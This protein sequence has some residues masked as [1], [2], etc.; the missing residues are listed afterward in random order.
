MKL[1]KHATIALTSASAVVFGFGVFVA[2]VSAQEIDLVTPEI[3]QQLQEVL[4]A[5]DT[6]ELLVDALTQVESQLAEY[7][8]STYS[9][10]V[11][12][13]QDVLQLKQI[14]RE[15]LEQLRSSLSTLK[16]EDKQEYLQKIRLRRQKSHEQISQLRSDALGKQQQLNQEQKTQRL[17]ELD[18]RR[19]LFKENLKG[20][21]EQVQQQKVEADAEL[22]HRR[23]LFTENLNNRLEA[24]QERQ[25][26]ANEK[27]KNRIEARE[28]RLT[29]LESRTETE[30]A[31]DAKR[32]AKAREQV[33][34]AIDSQPSN[35]F[36]QIGYWLR[37]L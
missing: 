11:N 27:F 4:G 17:E 8:V 28:A 33:K 20:R 6:D 15:Y 10:K 5:G 22:E 13:S 29:E 14:R 12:D 23:A 16:G 26:S 3:S 9:P 37:G 31:I 35:L 2:H 34:G 19:T 25:L 30:K 18:K 36:E 7:N 32:Q 21:Q 1:S 24:A